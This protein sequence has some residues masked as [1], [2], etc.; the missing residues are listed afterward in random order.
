MCGFLSLRAESPQTINQ[1]YESSILCCWIPYSIWD[2]L[3]PIFGKKRPQS[4]G[5]HGHL[6]P[7]LCHWNSLSCASVSAPFTAQGNTCF[8]CAQVRGGGLSPGFTFG[9]LVLWNFIRRLFLELERGD[10]TQLFTFP[11]EPREELY[12]FNCFIPV[13]VFIGV[14][15]KVLLPNMPCLYIHLFALLFCFQD[16]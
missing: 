1:S 3:F 5:A 12:I 11:E 6:N 7:W 14:C 16:P 10:H 8:S 4:A 13:K 2:G 9:Y 15:W